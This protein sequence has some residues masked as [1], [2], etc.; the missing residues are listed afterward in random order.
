V[1]VLQGLIFVVLLTSET[2][3]GRFAIFRASTSR[4]R[5]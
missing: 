3:Y 5:T 2:L 1:L 4:D